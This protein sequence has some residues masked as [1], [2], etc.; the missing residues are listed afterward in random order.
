MT[1]HLKRQEAINEVI[2]VFHTPPYFTSVFVLS[3]QSNYGT[4]LVLGK[5][6]FKPSKVE[7]RVIIIVSPNCFLV[8]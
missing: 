2:P 4:L 1:Q 6:I 7:H 8:K 3:T 5:Q